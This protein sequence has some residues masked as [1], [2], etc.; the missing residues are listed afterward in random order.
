MRKVLALCLLLLLCWVTG[1]GASMVYAQEQDE[2]EQTA[3]D[4]I[5]VE[6]DWDGYMPDMY[7][8]GDQAFIISMGTIFPA[9][10]LNNGEK[11]SHHFNPPVG[12]NGQ[13]AFTYFFGPHFFLGAEVGVK[14]NYTLAKNVVFLIPFGLR[15]GWQFVVKRFEF[16]VYMTI[17]A[18]PQR[19]LNLNYVGFMLKGGAAM[20]F[21][22]SPE[23]SFGLNTDWS[24][25]PQRP[26]KE[27]KSFDRD[28][29]VDANIVGLT[30]SARY[31]F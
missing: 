24:W 11:M 15:T 26:L 25:Y 1:Q 4:D 6:D 12:G 2:E 23:W 13:L 27:D 22:F 18:A 3:D 16:P 19:Y 7:S 10:F 31:H 30:I 9:V 21:R 8:R 20:Y 5:S 29:N 14:F 28:K 17:G